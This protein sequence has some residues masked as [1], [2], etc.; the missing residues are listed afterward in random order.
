[1]PDL[2]SRLD[3][4][5]PLLT[6]GSRD[7][8]SR[9]QTMRNAI[10]WSYDLLTPREQMVVCRLAVFAGGFTLDA[11]EQVVA[12][13]HGQEDLWSDLDFFDDL[14][15]LIDASLLQIETSI[16]GDVRYRMLETIREF[17]LERLETRG[18][19]A[20]VRHRH[21]AWF[22]ALAGQ[23][24]FAFPTSDSHQELLRLEAEQANL[25]AAFDWL[26]ETGEYGLLLR[27]AAAM[28]RSWAAL[29]HYHEGHERLGRALSH[30]DHSA[31]DR[32]TALVSFGFIKIYM[33]L[34]REAESD[35]ISALVRSREDHDT[36]NAAWSLIGLGALASMDGDFVR[37]TA[38][39]E[40]CIAVARTIPTLRTARVF[41]G[42]A[43]INLAV[44]ARSRGDY[45]VAN[46]HLHQALDRMRDAGDLAGMVMS[47]GDLGDLARDQ[48]DHTLAFELYRE[49]LDLSQ[50]RRHMP[51]PTFLV[52]SVGI[53]AVIVGQPEHGVRLLG[54]AEAIRERSGLRFNVAENV[55]ALHQSLTDARTVLGPEVFATAWAAGRNVRGQEVIELAMQPFSIPAAPVGRLSD[56]A[57]L[58]RR[59]TQIAQ[60]VAAGQ[61][62]AAIAASLFLSVRTVENHVAHILAKLGVH[63]RVDVG[64]AMGLDQESLPRT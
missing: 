12:A 11:A 32:T 61:T 1:M 64:R 48:G 24:D 53:L 60:L 14:G 44:I 8:P 5:L 62:D 40:D 59:E 39:L 4:R 36:I 18:E 42:W 63:A 50:E 46:E 10:G 9:L 45:S 21:A 26:E 34:A 7:K 15:T 3:R 16:T 29:G 28:G 51:A 52:E 57:G 13:G 17:A 43:L 6:G 47:L 19:S 2:L 37:G 58:T 54:A 31:P 41:E 49:G 27:L 20:Q 35:L 22:A 33:G 56:S 25:R 38:L 55:I 30:S 23:N